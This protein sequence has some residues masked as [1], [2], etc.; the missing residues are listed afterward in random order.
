MSFIACRRGAFFPWL[1]LRDSFIYGATPPRSAAVETSCG[2]SVGVGGRA[3]RSLPPPPASRDCL[4][5]GKGPGSVEEKCRRP[6]DFSFSWGFL[7]QVPSLF[8]L[9]FLQGCLCEDISSG[10]DACL[11]KIPPP[12]PPPPQNASIKSRYGPDSNKLFATGGRIGRMGLEHAKRRLEQKKRCKNSIIFFPLRDLAS[13]SAPGIFIEPSVCGIQSSGCN[14]KAFCTLPL[15]H[16]LPSLVWKNCIKVPPSCDRCDTHRCS[17]TNP[18]IPR[19]TGY[20]GV[21][22]YTVPPTVIWHRHPAGG[23]LGLTCIKRNGGG[24]AGVI[25]ISTVAVTQH[26]PTQ[27][28]G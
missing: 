9:L 6:K 22:H 26:D 11:I 20:N 17:D 24:V 28:K 19:T 1:H 14:K 21:L 25:Y 23:L 4:S 15:P 8:P 27:W 16:P 7:P 18:T 10:G 13:R 5:L 12:L 3:Y 2:S